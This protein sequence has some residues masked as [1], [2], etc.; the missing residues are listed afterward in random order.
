M[1][2]IKEHSSSS[3]AP[4]TYY[5]GNAA[6]LTIAIAVD[7]NTAGEKCT[8]KAAKEYISL[9]YNIPA[10]DNAREVYKKMKKLNAKTLNIA[11]NGIYTF[12]KHGIYQSE[13][14]DYILELLKPLQL[15]LGIDKIYT[16]GQTGVDMAG[17]YAAYMLD[18]DCEVTLPKGFKIRFADG[19]DSNMNEEVIRK[20]IVERI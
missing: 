15:H 9:D 13:I 18:I 2:I 5:N 20:M 12:H 6:D 16:G 11:G 1:L 3:Y 10:I 8:Q 7:F 17:A 4:R 19:T 14:K